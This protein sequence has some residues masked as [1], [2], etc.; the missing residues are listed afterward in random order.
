MTFRYPTR[1]RYS[2]TAQDGIIHHPS[3]V[4]YFEI[5]RI[6][7]MRSL[8]CNINELEK[9]KIL[10]PVV[11][12]AVKYHKPLYSSEDIEIQVSIDSFTKVRFTL[13]YVILKDNVQVTTGTTSHCFINEAFKP[14]PIPQNLLHSFEK[15]IHP[16]L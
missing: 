7:F 14:I 16:K 3:Y 9:Q 11:D 2:E 6:E 13:K 10:C 12:L 5:A 4:I 1:T 15:L 8:G